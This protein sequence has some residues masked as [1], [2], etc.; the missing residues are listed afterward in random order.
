MDNFCSSYLPTPPLGQDMTQGHFFKRSL[1]GLNLELSFSKAEEPSL[2]YYLPIAGGRI[3]GFMPF[4]RV[5]VQC[6]MQSVS[7]SI[8]TR[9]FVSISYDDNRYT[10]GT[11]NF[12]SS[13]L[14][15]R[16]S[17][18]RLLSLRPHKRRFKRTTLCQWKLQR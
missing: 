4:P 18:F 6:E 7:S 8:W 1:T 2:P 16:L 14:L 17:T 5:L 10:T 15:T 12:Y 3:M 13:F 9:V 11:S